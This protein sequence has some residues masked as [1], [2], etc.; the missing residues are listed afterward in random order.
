[1]GVFHSAPDEPG[2]SKNI[3]NTQK[4][5]T[6]TR[7]IYRKHGITVRQSPDGTL[8]TDLT[9]ATER[10]LRGVCE[11]SG[12]TLE[13]ALGDALA[14]SPRAIPRRLDRLATRQTRYTHPPKTPGRF[15]LFT[16]DLSEDMA[17]LLRD[18]EEIGI[19][20]VSIIDEAV[21]V[22]LSQTHPE[23]FAGKAV[24]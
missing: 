21:R 16:V 13:I 15:R 2:L 8:Q 1:M 20:A 5:H 14:G 4:H 12:T 10:R 24:A 11:E 6:M 23:L 19:S 3:L 22:H 7:T 9:K 17:E 18:A